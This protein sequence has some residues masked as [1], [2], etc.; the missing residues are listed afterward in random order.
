MPSKQRPKARGKSAAAETVARSCHR[1]GHNPLP[2]IPETCAPTDPTDA[3]DDD[4]A[5]RV[6]PEETLRRRSKWTNA[7][8]GGWLEQLEKVSQAIETPFWRR[9]QA[10]NLP[11]DEPV[12]VMAPTP[13][14]PRKKK[15]P[16]TPACANLEGSTTAPASARDNNVVEPARISV[17]AERGGRFGF[18]LRDPPR[19]TYVGSQSLD[20]FQGRQTNSSVTTRKGI[21]H[22][23]ARPS[24]SPLSVLSQEDDREME[25]VNSSPPQIRKPSNSPSPDSPRQPEG[26]LSESESEKLY[27]RAR[28]DGDDIGFRSDTENASLHSRS[29]DSTANGFQE[30]VDE[31]AAASVPET[32]QCTTLYHST[33]P[34]SSYVQQKAIQ[35]IQTFVVRNRATPSGFQQSTIRPLQPPSS[36]QVMAASSRQQPP[37]QKRGV[38]PRVSCAQVQAAAAPPPSEP[39]PTSPHLPCSNSEKLLHRAGVSYDLLE[40]HHTTNRRR[41]SPSPNFLAGTGDSQDFQSSKRQCLEPPEQPEEDVIDPKS[42]STKDQ[43][44]RGRYS[45][46]AKGTVPIKPTLIAFYPPLWV[47]LLNLAKA[48][49]R[50]YVAVENAFPR[51]EDAVGGQC[52]EVLMEV[53]AHFEAQGWE[54]KAGYY[55]THKLDMCRLLFN[56][57]LTFRSDL[58]KVAIKSLRADYDLYPP[59]T[60]KTEEQRI[61]AVKKK[62]DDLLNTA[63]YLRGE[64]D[65][66]GRASN[67]AHRALKNICLTFY[68]SNSSKCLRQFTEFQEYVPYRAL[69]LVAAM[70][71][72]LLSSFRKHGIDNSA[73]VNSQD[74][75]EAYTALNETILDVLDHPHHGPK[76]NAM[77]TDWAQSGMTGYVTKHKPTECT[78]NEF[79][80]ILD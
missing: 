16:N 77:L 72:A 48:H 49:M 4:S 22:S 9:E 54:V 35:P 25:I 11:D 40:H 10:V 13:R 73:Q 51:L 59:T 17:Q 80:P 19:P 46:N 42:D 5:A 18:Q 55:P 74:V 52:R 47:K 24:G 7:G 63:R 8:T 41:R 75:D 2:S 57:I 60:A 26:F 69:A 79:A 65:G 23:P 15:V 50:L 44:R 12:N 34:R 53:I 36:Q 56:D 6:R 45:R 27:R 14:R 20:T 38:T 37:P 31:R 64:P 61:A 29:G 21:Q 70:V 66:Q 76:L 71:H 28:E 39:F 67:F 30:Y 58:K 3:Q 62:A 32:T 1:S 43:L 33:P 78:R 68:Y